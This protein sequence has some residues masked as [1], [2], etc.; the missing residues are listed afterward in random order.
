MAADVQLAH[1]HHIPGTTVTPVAVPAPVA[2]FVAQQLRLDGVLARPPAPSPPQHAHTAQPVTQPHQVRK[3]RRFLAPVEKKTDTA[4]I[5]HPHSDSNGVDKLFG[6][7]GMRTVFT[8]TDRTIPAPATGQQ[9][10]TQDDHPAGRLPSRTG[11]LSMTAAAGSLMVGCRAGRQQTGKQVLASGC[12][13][14]TRDGGRWPADSI[15]RSRGH[16]RRRRAP[17]GTPSARPA[18]HQCRRAPRFGRAQ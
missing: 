1:A 11:S 3:A 14:A 6:S 17:G 13:T 9:A 10:L 8:G 4:V 5:S 18:L 15:P 12:V 7:S 16:R 2:A